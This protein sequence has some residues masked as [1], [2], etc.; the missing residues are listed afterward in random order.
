MANKPRSEKKAEKERREREVLDRVFTLFLA[1]IAAECYVLL[2]YRKFVRGVV[3]D[4]A[5]YSYVVEYGRYI[6]TLVMIAG[7]VL[8]VW[9]RQERSGRIGAAIAAAG[10]FFAFAN[11]LMFAVHPQG[12]IFLCTLIPILTVLGLVYFLFQR[13]FFFD[14][15][16]L[17]GTMFTLWLCRRGLGTENWNTKV[18]A[19]A[20][21]VLVGL[22]AVT[23]VLRYLQQQNGVF[24][25]RQVFPKGCDY[26]LL[27]GSV[28][29]AFVTIAAALA[30]PASAFYT[31][32]VV[33][34]AIFALAIYYTTKLM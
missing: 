23:G 32:W 25:G 3:Q 7:L 4:M 5:T 33:G 29:V 2:I 11:I 13:E 17:G 6:G 27:Y 28:A 31:M 24:R 30:V 9:K 18:T 19:G 26:R 22:G 10:A 16:I 1:G 20:L 14:S 34:V 15:V 8:A 12:T 21:V